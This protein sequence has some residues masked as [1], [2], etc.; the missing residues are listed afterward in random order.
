[1]KCPHC[2]TVNKWEATTCEKCGTFLVQDSGPDS[3]QR[4]DQD[5]LEESIF[6]DWPA[7]EPSPEVPLN[8][9]PPEKPDPKT[10]D[11]YYHK[12]FPA[13][14]YGGYVAAVIVIIIVLTFVVIT[15]QTDRTDNGNQNVIT[16]PL[17]GTWDTSD[18]TTFLVKNNWPSGQMTD[19][20]QENRTMTLVITGTQDPSM[21]QVEMSYLIISSNISSGAMYGKETDPDHFQ[22]WVSGSTLTLFQDGLNA[23][24]TFGSGSM[25]GTWDHTF[26]FPNFTEEINTG[27]NAISLIRR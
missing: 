15:P 3:D 6:K 5:V 11:P 13:L 23:V 8:E 4:S 7:P 18:L 12:R 10:Y 1:M 20:G 9:I 14:L 24:F 2:G 17:V 27:D 26:T 25:R 22:G 16:D 21:V 19:I